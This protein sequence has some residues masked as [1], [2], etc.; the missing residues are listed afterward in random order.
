MAETTL[1]RLDAGTDHPYLKYMNKKIDENELM[2]REKAQILTGHDQKFKQM[3]DLLDLPA[4][5]GSNSL[6][7][8]LRANLK[9]MMV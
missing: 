2:I 1:Q 3:A 8:G 4:A 9:P 6:L 5:E 7:E